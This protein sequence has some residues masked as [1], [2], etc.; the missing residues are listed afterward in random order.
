M[1]CPKCGSNSVNVQV[2]AEAK[3]R[4]ILMSALIVIFWLIVAVLTY[5][6]GLIG[7]VIWFLIKKGSKTKAYAVCQHCGHKWKV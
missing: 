4:G 1:V 3:K 5:G 6:I 7:L 2:V